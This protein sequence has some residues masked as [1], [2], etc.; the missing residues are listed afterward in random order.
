M[1]VIPNAE[2]GARLLPIFTVLVGLAATLSIA[3]P[4]LSQDTRAALIARQQAEK[5]RQLRKYTP[6]KVEAVVT[7]VQQGFVSGPNGAYPM[8]G[9]VYPGG[10]VALGVG[11]RRYYGDRT[12]FDLKSLYSI[13][14]YKWL[15]L[16][17]DAFGLLRDRLELHARVGWRDAPQVAFY[18]LGVGTSNDDRTNFG[19]QNAYAGGDA[20]LRPVFPFVLGAAVTYEDYDTGPG[21]GHHRSIEERFSPESVPGL[22]AGPAFVHARAS[23]AVDWRPSSG[24]ARRGGL[25]EIRYHGYRDRADVYS[26]DRVDGEVVQHI[27]LLREKYVVS[28][29]G[30]VESVVDD[31]AEV[32]FFMLPALGSGSTLRGFHSWR[33]R[34]RH[35]LLLQ[36]ELRW[37]PNRSA[38]DVALFYDAGKVVSRRRDLD[39]DGLKS[40]VGL[41]FRFHS[42]TATP[43]RL[44]LARSNEGYRLVVAGAAAF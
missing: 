22:G 19:L 15:E 29:R 1:Y 41:G 26:F 39:L 36:G 37:A 20:R 24:F 35:S 40:D 23:A 27:P 5:A 12:F 18:G 9:S 44:E 8:F 34:D 10:S 17:T 28:L 21:D 16:S 2:R 38:L 32:P 42:F 30:R 4:A 13:R 31:D 33:F 11:Y 14:N 43:V 3:S 25:Y 7:R 6:S